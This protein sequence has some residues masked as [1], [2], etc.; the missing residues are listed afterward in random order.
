M[1]AQMIVRESSPPQLIQC[2]DGML[3]RSTASA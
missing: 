2:P 1:H 3:I